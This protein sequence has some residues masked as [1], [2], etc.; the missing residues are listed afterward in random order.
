MPQ[1]KT[2]WYRRPAF[3]LGMLVSVAS[4]VLLFTL[5]DIR[6]LLEKLR[7]ADLRFVLLAAFIVAISCYLRAL[8]WQTLLGSE[9]S[10]WNIFHTENISYLLNT[11]FPLHVGDAARP[12]LISRSINKRN[13]SP[14]EALSTF[15]IARTMDTVLV[16]C[17][18]GIV[19]PTLAVP[20]VIKTA[21][22]T[23][24]V[25][26][27]GVFAVMVIG[28]FA[29]TRLVTTVNA[30]LNRFLPKTTAKRLTEWL[31]SFLKGL[32]ALRDP[33]RLLGMVGASMLLWLC[34][35]AFYIAMIWAVWPSPPLSWPV[36]A[37][38]SGAL[39]F[40]LPSSPGG[41]GVFHAAIVLAMS[42]Y[43]TAEIAAAYAVLLNA[44]ELVVNV[45]F[46]I[47]SFTATG[48]SIAS[49]TAAT[50]AEQI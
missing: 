38:A 25:S 9:V 19:L 1:Q 12:F 22:Y 34:Y 13:V 2:P 36:L 35:V 50:A 42:P 27:L 4:I 6:T 8:R 45:I 14:L 41:I 23:L 30:L 47:Y 26:A 21:G 44:T 40:G 43:L 32:S 37:T 24:F 28:A 20:E 10:F 11:V 39:S 48:T 33:R 15:V 5:V 7:Q 31:D 46:G 49:V 29:R 17:L 18:L 3:W 16:V